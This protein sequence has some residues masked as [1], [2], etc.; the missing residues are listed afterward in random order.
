MPPLVVKSGGQDCFGRSLI[1][2]GWYPE[3]VSLDLTIRS[4]DQPQLALKLEQSTRPQMANASMK[5][6]RRFASSFVKSRG[7]VI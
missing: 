1:R 4:T 3:M 5:A 7:T 2:W 6:A